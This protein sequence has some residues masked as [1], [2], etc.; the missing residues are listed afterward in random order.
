MR[1]RCAPIPLL[2]LQTS[3]DLYGKQRAALGDFCFWQSAHGCAARRVEPSL[4]CLKTRCSRPVLTERRG[5]NVACLKRLPR[6]HG[7][8]WERT[9]KT[10]LCMLFRMRLVEG[11]CG[12]VTCAC[13]RSTRS[14]LKHPWV[15]W[16]RSQK[17]KHVILHPVQTPFHLARMWQF[18]N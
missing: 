7:L 2:F 11:A 4:H 10:S 15:T 8:T 5:T 17:K 1:A 6:T 16:E 12:A 3:R 13:P 18:W 14:S 9:Q